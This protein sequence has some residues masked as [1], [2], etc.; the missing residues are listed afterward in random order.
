MVK[1]RLKKG[2]E[3]IVIAGKEK[4]KTGKITKMLPKESRVFVENINFVK[5]HLKS[6][7]PENKK[8]NIVDKHVSMHISNVMFYSKAK[9]AERIGFKLLEGKKVRFAKKSNEQLG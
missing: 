1:H 6:E 3:V 2:D 8:P 9:N 7:N 4:G 5:K